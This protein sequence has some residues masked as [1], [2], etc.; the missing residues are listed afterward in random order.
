[1]ITLIVMGAQVIKHYIDS[2][3]STNETNKRLDEELKRIS[4]L[5]ERVKTLEK[6]VTDPSENLRKEIDKLNQ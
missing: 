2:K 1:M 3:S 6:I 4:E 5:E